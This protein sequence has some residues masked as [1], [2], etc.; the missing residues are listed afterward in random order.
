MA[1]AGIA[2]LIALVVIRCVARAGR[3][4]R[5]Q[6]H[7]AQNRRRCRKTARRRVGRRSSRRR[8]PIVAALRSSSRSLRFYELFK[9]ALEPIVQRAVRRRAAHLASRSAWRAACSPSTGRN[10]V[11]STSKRATAAKL[12]R[13][14]R[15][16]RRRDRLGDEGV[17]AMNDL[18]AASVVGLR[19]DARRRRARRRARHGLDA[20]R[21]LLARE[22]EDE[23]ESARASSQRRD[24]YSIC[25]ASLAWAAIVTIVGAC[26]IGYVALASFVVDQVVWVT[27]V[28]TAGYLLY[29]LADEG[30]TRAMQPGSVRRPRGD[31]QH[32][33]ARASCLRQIATLLR[34]RAARSC[35][36]S[37]CVMLILAPWGVES[38]DML[39][40]A[41]R[42]L[43]RL[44]GRRRHDLAVD[45]SLIALGLFGA[46]V[47]VHARRAALA[48]GQ[49]PA[50]RRELDT[51]LR[52][53]IRTSVGYVGFFVAGGLALGYI[54]P[55]A[56]T[57]SPSSPARCRSASASACSRS[58]TISS[59]A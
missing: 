34:R 15:V 55:V 19:A 42:G 4:L 10:G 1:A 45:A 58:S 9:S 29:A 26:A 24:W 17:E 23:A 41:A 38:D 2:A 12:S 56:S 6:S 27:F 22:G 44:Q 13:A 52:N 21:A 39:G 8:C 30:I 37:S 43:L 7:D 40:N 59:R 28:G 11:C 16:H 47:A 31:E 5:R 20:L 32:R 3:V 25:C 54:G 57:S 48:R 51:G 46:G 50:A 33:P 36:R 14:A 18:V 49:I 53:S 35:W